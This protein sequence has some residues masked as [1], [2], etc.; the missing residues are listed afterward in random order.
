MR[1]SGWCPFGYTPLLCHLRRE[2]PLVRRLLSSYGCIRLLIR[3]DD[4]LRLSAFPAPPAA[5]ASG[6]DE[7]SQLL[8][9]K[10]PDM[11]RVSDRAGSTQ[12][13]RLTSCVILPSASDNSVG[14][15]DDPDFAAQYLACRFP[16]STLRL[17]PRG[18]TRMTRGRSDSPFLLR[19]ELSSTI[20]CQLLL[21]HYPS[22]H[23][24]AA[25]AQGWTT[26][27][28]A[29]FSASRELADR[30]DGRSAGQ[31]SADVL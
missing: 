9:R 11:H 18:Y 3:V 27:H 13:L 12:G 20:S 23:S 5:C 7:I 21:A 10:L 15:P 14:I 16:L 31:S 25:A 26:R 24:I 1:E 2:H 4:R 6:T 17:H 29:E 30:S 8:C 19:I 28:N 22:W